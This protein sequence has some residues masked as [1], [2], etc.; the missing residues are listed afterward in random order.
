MKTAIVYGSTGQVGS[1]FVEELLSQSY[2]VVGVQRRSSTNNTE[3]L[4][5]VL[6]HPSFSLIEGDIVDPSSVNNIISKYQPEI[7]VNMAAMSHVHTSFSQPSYTYDVVAKGPLLLLEA[8]RHYSTATRFIQASSSEMFG[9]NYSYTYDNIKYQNEYTT[10]S[11]NSPYAI[12][13]VAAHHAVSLYRRA[14]GLYA[15]AAIFFNMESPR[16][17]ENFVTRKITKYI[18][19]LMKTSNIANIANF[20]K[21]KLGNLRAVRDWGYAPDY[22]RGAM[23]MIQKSD[24]DDF[25]FGTGECYAVED[26][27]TEAFRVVDIEDWTK[28]VEVDKDL[29][30]PCEVPYLHSDA[31][32][33][34]QILGWEPSITFKELVEIMVQSDIEKSAKL[35][36][37]TI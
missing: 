6:S 5:G 9:S 19:N 24:P 33:A 11:P 34:K 28:F 32:R 29:Y 36:R 26:F 2:R 25:V 12:A 7:C 23:L 30:R 3:N 17:G 13:K 8:I 1:Y 27:L 10:L 37:P 14:Y 35:S 15:Y 16:R 31:K 18:A 20:P 21:L 4:Q 22:V